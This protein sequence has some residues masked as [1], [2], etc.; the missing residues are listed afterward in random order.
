MIWVSIY[1]RS[2]EAYRSRLS[3]FHVCGSSYVEINEEK[4]P[5]GKLY[6]FL[7]SSPDKITI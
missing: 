3:Q 6:F 5:W 1:S 4:N 7:G 2:G